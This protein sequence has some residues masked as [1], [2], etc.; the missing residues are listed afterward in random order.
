MTMPTSFNTTMPNIPFFKSLYPPYKSTFPN[1]KYQTKIKVSKYLSKLI[2][3]PN[4]CFY[5][6]HKKPNIWWRFWQYILLGWR[7]ENI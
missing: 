1:E 6:E 2:I 4:V 7:W 5:F 3:S